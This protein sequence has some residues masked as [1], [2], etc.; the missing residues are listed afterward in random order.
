MKRIIRNLC[1]AAT[2]LCGAC[3]SE[4]SLSWSTSPNAT[5]PDNIPNAGAVSDIYIAP[6]DSQLSGIV[7]PSV[8]SVASVQFTITGGWD[9]DFKLVL[10]HADGT[11]SQSVTLLNTLLGGAAANSG[12]NNVTLAAGNTDINSAASSSSTAAISGAWAPQGG[13]NFSSFQN[14]SPTGDWIL[15]VTDNASG[16]QGVLSGWSLNL[17]V[18]P[19]PVNVALGI[20]G[21]M[22]GILAFARSRRA[23]RPFEGIVKNRA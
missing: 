15:Y 21:G 13:V 4:G 7:N 12:F 2:V 11:T 20:F 23:K 6:G 17:D 8:A 19:E 14:I 18:V 1:V 9:G 16:E 3:Q 10:S 5:I 22:M